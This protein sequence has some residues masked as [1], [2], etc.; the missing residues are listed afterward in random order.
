[1]K[2]KAIPCSALDARRPLSCGHVPDTAVPA[3]SAWTPLTKM[4]RRSVARTG[5]SMWLVSD[6]TGVRSSTARF[7][8]AGIV[9]SR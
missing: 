8:P 3:G 1:M 7:V 2:R 5:S 4:A 6:A 9:T